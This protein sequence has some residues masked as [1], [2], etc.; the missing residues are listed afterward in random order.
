MASL[1]RHPDPILTRDDLP[2]VPP[3]LLDPSSVFNPGAARFLGRDRLLLRVQGRSRESFLMPARSADGLRFEVEARAIT[4]D[5]LAK[6]GE[7]IHHV[8]DPRLTVVGDT[9]YAVFAADLD[10]AC[11]LGVAATT[12]FRSFELIGLD[13]AGD[14]RNGVLFPEQVRGR[15]LRLERPNRTA[16]DGGPTSG[17]TIVLAES[18]DLRSWRPVAPVMSG[19][20][21]YW[22]ERIGS[23]PP[24]VKTRAG[25]L[26]LYH[27]VATHFQSANVYQAGAVLLDLDDPSRV[28]ARTW[29]NVLEPRATWE[30]TGQVPNVV[31]PS[32]MIVD[33]VD[34]DG[35][36][37][38]GSLVR[39]YYGAADTVVGLA[40][41]TIAE[42]ID[43][44]RDPEPPA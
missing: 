36:A 12:D 9:C 20:W 43:A 1:Q 22:D 31:F 2:D 23:G 6:A 8:Y 18:D 25:W 24:P 32:G 26:H 15:W 3:R 21:R 10:D 14:S 37:E 5:G 7:R 11:R 19:R 17:E 34:A 38:P 13:P 35:F 28:L 40:T 39:V 16:L 42:L 44:C 33:R 29:N 27:G 30:L 41:A 4:I